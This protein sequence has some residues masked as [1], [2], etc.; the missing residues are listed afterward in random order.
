M[1][2]LGALAAL[3]VEI[4]RLI[5]GAGGVPNAIAA[6]KRVNDTYTKVD[7]AKTPGEYQDAA[8][9]VSDLESDS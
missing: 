9:A 2:T 8:K 7:D 1:T 3:A 6:L 5:R 4:I